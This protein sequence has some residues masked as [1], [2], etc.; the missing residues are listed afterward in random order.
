VQQAQQL[1]TGQASFRITLQR[2]TDAAFTQN[3]T[4]LVSGEKLVSI[5]IENYYMKANGINNQAD[6]MPGNRYTFSETVN[7]N[8]F[9][10]VAASPSNYYYYRLLFNPVYTANINTTST[11][12]V[13]DRSLSVMQL[14]R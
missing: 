12:S 13:N 5:Q 8:Y 6:I 14:K 7:L 11:Y 2:A 10:D 1:S 9:D 3:L 4:S